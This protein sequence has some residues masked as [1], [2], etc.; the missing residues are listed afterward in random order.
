MFSKT[1]VIVFEQFCILHNIFDYSNETM[2]IFDINMKLGISRYYHFFIMEYFRIG[3]LIFRNSV[4][5]F[6][7]RYKFCMSLTL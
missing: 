5:K 2:K 4:R 1:P 7:I 6:G 3:S